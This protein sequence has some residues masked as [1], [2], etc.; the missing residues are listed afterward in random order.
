LAIGPTISVMQTT[1]QITLIIRLQVHVR[2]HSVRCQIVGETA[3]LSRV[4]NMSNWSHAR[5]ETGT[6]LKLAA[7]NGHCPRFPDY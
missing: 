2:R 4:L 3:G 7:T 6:H 5:S 1:N